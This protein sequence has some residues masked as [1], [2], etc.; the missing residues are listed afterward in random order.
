MA[1]KNIDKVR[2]STALYNIKIKKGLLDK[3][4]IFSIEAIARD[5]ALNITDN[6]P[7]K[8]I[9]FSD[10]LSIPTSLRNTNNILIIKLLSHLKKKKKKSSTGYL[11]TSAFTEIEKLTWQ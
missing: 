3:S 7:V 8:L 9:V 2:C 10:L 11:A 4:S 5:L 1:Q 6:G